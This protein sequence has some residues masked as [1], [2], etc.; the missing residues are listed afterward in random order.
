MM[1][2]FFQ[3]QWLHSTEPKII[4]EAALFVVYLEPSSSLPSGTTHMQV[5]NME[6][7]SVSITEPARRNT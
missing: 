3:V 5:N 2:D 7:G 6:L 4:L 1:R